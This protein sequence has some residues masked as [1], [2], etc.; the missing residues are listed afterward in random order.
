MNN[1]LDN[2]TLS[3]ILIEISLLVI[4]VAIFYKTYT[5]HELLEVELIN[6]HEMISLSDENS[7]E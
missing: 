7:D 2:K 4:L 1:K 5:L 3:I 6:R